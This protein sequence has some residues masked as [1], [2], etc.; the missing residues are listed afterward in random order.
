VVLPFGGGDQFRGVVV[1]EASAKADGLRLGAVAAD[2]SQCQS[3]RAEYL[4]PRTD[5]RSYRA[6]RPRWPR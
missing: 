3:R 1:A 5:V 4:R 2:V 6:N